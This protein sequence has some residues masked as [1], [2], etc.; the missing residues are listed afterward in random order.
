MPELNQVK[1]VSLKENRG[2]GSDGCKRP[3]EGKGESPREKCGGAKVLFI[4]FS[5]IDHSF[6]VPS[7]KKSFA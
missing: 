4:H 2:F 5:V 1:K 3:I 7:K 6:S